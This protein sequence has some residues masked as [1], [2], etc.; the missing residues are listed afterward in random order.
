MPKMNILLFGKPFSSSIELRDCKEESRD[1]G[2]QAVGQSL[3]F[4]QFFRLNRYFLRT[5]AKI[6]PRNLNF[7]SAK[8]SGSSFKLGLV[9][10]PKD[11][12]NIKK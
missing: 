12:I 7:F 2:R 4:Y 1:F 11:D 5:W 10:S 6:I 8:L 9:F 3:T